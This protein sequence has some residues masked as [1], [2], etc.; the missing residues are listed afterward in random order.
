MY[1]PFI[2][3]VGHHM[4]VC[5][6]TEWQ[7]NMSMQLQGTPKSLLA[8]FNTAPIIP[9]LEKVCC[10]ML[11]Q[12]WPRLKPI[13]DSD[14]LIPATGTRSP[15]EQVSPSLKGHSRREYAEMCWCF[16]SAC[17]LVREWFAVCWC[18]T[19]N[20]SVGAQLLSQRPSCSLKTFTFPVHVVNVQY[21]KYFKRG[22]LF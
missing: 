15:L 22:F 17:Q 18:T 8:K 9:S 14:W 13:H 16:P 7:R 3:Y 1:S 12:R 20:T 4:S 6:L 5:K 2:L 10:V 11:V 19:G 21:F